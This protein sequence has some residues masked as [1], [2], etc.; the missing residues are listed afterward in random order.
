WPTRPSEADPATPTRSSARPVT[1]KGS[2]VCGASA[3]GCS[4]ACWAG[5]WAHSSAGTPQLDA[6][7]KHTLITRSLAR[8]RTP[9]WLMAR[10]VWCDIALSLYQRHT[11]P[12]L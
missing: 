9:L 2:R 8:A 7:H 4:G 5:V 11:H 12:T 1:T 6:I 10:L 3:D